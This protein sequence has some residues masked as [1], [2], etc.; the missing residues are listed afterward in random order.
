MINNKKQEKLP[1][2]IRALFWL[3][4]SIIGVPTIPNI[5]KG[6]FKDIMELGNDFAIIGYI[7]AIFLVVIST[8]NL[9]AVLLGHENLREWIKQI[10]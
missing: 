6:I 3:I 9:I 1:A 4:L 7:T 2:E 5:F 8:L 10:N